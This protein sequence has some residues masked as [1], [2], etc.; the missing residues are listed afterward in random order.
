MGG[1]YE[2]RVPLAAIAGGRGHVQRRRRCV[3]RGVLLR[4][5]LPRG[6]WPCDDLVELRRVLRGK[7][8]KKKKGE[9][10]LYYL[11]RIVIYIIVSVQYDI[12]YT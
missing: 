12:N 2:V 8:N 5:P 1:P 3:R 10:V 11:Y 4:W 7:S 6:V 9:G